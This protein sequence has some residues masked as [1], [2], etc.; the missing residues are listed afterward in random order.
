ML[1][2]KTRGKHGIFWEHEYKNTPIFK[3]EYFLL[4][5]GCLILWLNHIIYYQIPMWGII[6]LGCTIIGFIIGTVLVERFRLKYLD[7]RVT[8][9]KEKL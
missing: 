4:G 7:R 3:L 5:C 1:S 8:E 9:E 2:D 6:L